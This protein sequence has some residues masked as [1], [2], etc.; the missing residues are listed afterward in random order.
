[1]PSPTIITVAE[2]DVILGTTEPWFSTLE[3]EKEQAL[4]WAEVYFNA[5]YTCVYDEDDV[6]SEI[7][8]GLAYLGNLYLTD[9]TVMFPIDSN[10]NVT[11]NKVKAGSVESAKSYASPTQKQFID[12][13]P[14][15]SALF[16]TYCDLTPSSVNSAR[17]A[18]IVRN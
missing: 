6:P 10:L 7:T 14:N 13:Y 1:M 15:V 16:S 18:P 2:A 9:P 8:E 5:N 11:S 4:G 12:Q 3:P 17:T